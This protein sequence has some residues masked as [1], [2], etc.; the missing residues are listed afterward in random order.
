[1]IVNNCRYRQKTENQKIFKEIDSNVKLIR[2]III[3]WIHFFFFL[4]KWY[5]PSGNSVGHVPVEHVTCS[6]FSFVRS[7]EDETE[8]AVDDLAPSDSAAVV[9]R[10]P[11]GASESV[12]DAVL[13]GHV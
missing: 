7:V 6:L 1:M 10:H 11:R 5:E 3:R 12:S 2:R 13:H 4:L 8:S 9:Q